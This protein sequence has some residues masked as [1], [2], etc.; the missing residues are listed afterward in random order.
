MAFVRRLFG[1]LWRALDGLRKAL[2]LIL[3]L[4][5]FAV[6]LIAVRQPLPLVPSR[7]ALVLRPS[8][9]LVEQLSGSVLDRSLGAVAGPRDPET[10][11]RDLTDAIRGA[12]QDERIVAMV[13]DTGE[14]AGGGLTKLKT[15]AAAL[16]DF[17]KAGKKIYAYGRYASQDQYY[18]MAQ[19]DEAYLDPAGAVEVAG[20]ASY[21]L[22]FHDALERLGVDVNVFKVGTHKT[23]TEMY[24]RQ[25]MSPEEREQTGAWLAPLWQSYQDGVEHARALPP[26][27]VAA[28]VRD[29]VTGLAAADG[30]AALFAQQRGLISGRKTWA[31]FEQQLITLV[32]KDEASH[33]FNAIG[34]DEYLAAT[35]PKAALSR[36]P[37]VQVAVVVASG[38]IVDGDRPPG[39]IGGDSFAEVLR[40]VRF[41]KDVKAVVLRIDSG[42]GSMLASEVIRQEVAA[43]KAAG[44]PVVASFSSVAASGGYYIAMNADEIWAEPTTITGSIGVFAVVPTFQR[45]LGKLGVASDGLATTPIAGAI[46]LERELDPS[47]KKILQ[48]GVEHAYRDFVGK[49]AEARGKKPEEIEKVAEGRVWVSTDAL[50]FGLIDHLG[51]VGDAIAAAAKRAQ[52]ESGGYA[53]SWREKELSWKELMVKQLRTESQAAAQTLGLVATP[54]PELTR[55]VDAAEATLRGLAAFNDP[56]RLYYYCGCELR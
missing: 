48:L 22:Y 21:G 28:Y 46:H 19:A 53:I 34:H 50:E 49:V 3:L 23:Y 40:K 33:S 1:V 26:G 31:E 32:G 55:V 30:D 2:H 24:T 16:A 44:K 14:L 39:E 36:R 35:R 45:T 6:L 20:F 8:G 54:H 42:G 52:L 47:V 11:V 9:R 29:A 38:H 43:L 15:V 37:P 56:R 51:N 5:I 4:L 25:D 10:L 13:L 27:T 17:R 41:D 18:L 7:A 12:T